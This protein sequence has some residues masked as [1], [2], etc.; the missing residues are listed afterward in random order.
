MNPNVTLILCLFFLLLGIGIGC[1]FTN[2]NQGNENNKTYPIEVIT[3]YKI[4][5][6]NYRSVMNVDSVKKD[7][8][9][10]DNIVITNNNI[11]EIKFK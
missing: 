5:D 9:F 8:I 3:E 7:S 1:K 11:K 4:G 10:K 2:N 6:H